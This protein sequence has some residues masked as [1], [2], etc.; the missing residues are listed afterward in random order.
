MCKEMVV[1]VHCDNLAAV[2]KH[3]NKKD[4][5][6]NHLLQVP[7]FM[8][9]YWELEETAVLTACTLAG[10][11]MN[12]FFHRYPKWPELQ[13]RCQSRSRITD[14]ASLFLTAQLLL[15][16][17]VTSVTKRAYKSGTE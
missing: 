15:A 12:V 1:T 16:V 5:K 17:R 13:L 8:K 6:L 2:A 11:I 7:Y 14:M 9:K 10:N 4:S 3:E